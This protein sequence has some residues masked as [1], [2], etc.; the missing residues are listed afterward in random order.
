MEKP[1][2]FMVEFWHGTDCRAREEAEAVNEIQALQIAH[3]RMTFAVWCTEP[4]FRIEI[5]SLES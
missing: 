2:K 5:K 4:A 3:M 1:R